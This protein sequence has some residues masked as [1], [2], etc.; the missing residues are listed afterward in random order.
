MSRSNKNIFSRIANINRIIDKSCD[1]FCN[2]TVEMNKDE[3]R[4]R[5]GE[6]TEWE[7]RKSERMREREERD[8]K[9]VGLRETERREATLCP[10]QGSPPHVSNS[11]PECEQR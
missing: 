10:I 9:G 4:D 1:L 8:G 3:E 7:E 2:E 6:G 5:S 11:G